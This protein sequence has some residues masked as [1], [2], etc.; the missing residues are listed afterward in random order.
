MRIP[1]TLGGLAAV[2]IGVARPSSVSLSTSADYTLAFD[3]VAVPVGASTS[4]VAVGFLLDIHLATSIDASA[5][6]ASDIALAISID[7]PGALFCPGAARGHE[8]YHRHRMPVSRGSGLLVA[9]HGCQHEGGRPH[10]SRFCTRW[11]WCP[12]GSVDVHHRGV[13]IAA[14]VVW[15]G[16]ATLIS[17]DACIANGALAGPSAAIRAVT[18]AL[19]TDAG[20]PLCYSACAGDVAWPVAP[21][22]HVATAGGLALGALA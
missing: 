6:T 14:A 8:W 5:T 15:A 3:D 4:T 10:G 17:L 1:T 12:V 21:G 13:P 7:T 19:V 16:R 18:G 9:G 20:A 11:Q 22:A 2:S